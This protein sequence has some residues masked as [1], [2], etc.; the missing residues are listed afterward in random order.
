MNVQ[1]A[2]ALLLEGRGQGPSKG[3]VEEEPLLAPFR[4]QRF[5]VESLPVI[6]PS[7]HVRWG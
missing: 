3:Q 1:L 4:K 7:I 5:R 2:A 6:A